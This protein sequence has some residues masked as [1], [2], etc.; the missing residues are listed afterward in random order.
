MRP[1][2]Q[3]ICSSVFTTLDVFDLKIEE[4]DLS[5]P[6]SDKSTWKISGSTVELCHKNIGISFKDKMRLIQ[7]VLELSKTF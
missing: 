4:T 2:G 6:S 1:L 3:S 7:P 5:K